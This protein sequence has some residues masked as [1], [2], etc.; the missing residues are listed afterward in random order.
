[1]RET[2]RFHVLILFLQ[3]L[4]VRNDTAPTAPLSTDTARPSTCASATT[5]GI[6]TPIARNIC[7][8]VSTA[9]TVR[10]APTSARARTVGWATNAPFLIAHRTVEHTASALVPTT[11]NVSPAG[12]ATAASK[13]AQQRSQFI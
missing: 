8:T 12:W 4:T 13:A 10:R 3:G 11:V 6:P 2:A 9:A 7:V 1:M 5:V